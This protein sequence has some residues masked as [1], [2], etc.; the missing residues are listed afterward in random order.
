MTLKNRWISIFCLVAAGFTGI[1]YANEVRL[2]VNHPMKVTYRIAHQNSGGQ[3]IFGE[4]QTIEVEKS[5]P[6]AVDL[7]GYE[8]AGLVPVTV[9]GHT[10][11]DSANKFNTP[12]QCSMTTDKS[13]TKG[14][15]KFT[16]EAKQ[17]SCSAQGGVFY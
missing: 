2:E 3:V 17:A 5:T 7:E 14:T 10:L 6:I 13:K 11:P 4:L 12:M 16:V 9:D 8:F 15:L 1:T